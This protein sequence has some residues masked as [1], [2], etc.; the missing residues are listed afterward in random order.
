MDQVVTTINA[1]LASIPY[2]HWKNADESFF[3]ALIHLIFSLLG[4]FLQSEV[5]SSHGRCDALVQTPQSIYCFEFKIDGSVETAIRQIR[6]RGYLDPY[7]D[8]QR[9]KFLVGVN[10]SKADRK[11]TD[12]LVGQATSGLASKFR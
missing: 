9:D 2:D 11:I 8:D 12:W 1:A 7:E 3:H 5:H 10:F 6:D 4:I